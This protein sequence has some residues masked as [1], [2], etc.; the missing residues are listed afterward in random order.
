[1]ASFVAG[2]N[3]FALLANAF[4]GAAKGA[5]DF[6]QLKQRSDALKEQKRQHDDNLALGFN[7]LDEQIRQFDIGTSERSRLETMALEARHKLGIEQ[8]QISKSATLGAASIRSRTADKDRKATIAFQERNAGLDEHVNIL[9]AH[10]VAGLHTDRKAHDVRLQAGETTELFDWERRADASALAVATKMSLGSPPTQAQIS[11]ARE[12]V[13]NYPGLKEQANQNRIDVAMSKAVARAGGGRTGGG[14]TGTGAGVDF[15]QAYSGALYASTQG[16][17]KT[18]LKRVLHTPKQDAFSS[19]RSQM[20]LDGDDNPFTARNIEAVRDVERASLALLRE[21]SPGPRRTNLEGQLERAMSPKSF[22]GVDP[23]FA[24]S[25]AELVATQQEYG[26]N[27]SLD[28]P[29]EWRKFTS[30]EAYNSAQLEAESQTARAIRP[31]AV[32]EEDQEKHAQ[33]LEARRATIAAQQVARLSGGGDDADAVTGA[34]GE[35]QSDQFWTFNV[36]PSL[37]ASADAPGGSFS[38][39]KPPIPNIPT[40]P[41]QGT[42]EYDQM[43]ADMQQFGG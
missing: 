25:V 3:K 29:N 39:P 23:S 21:H 36:G 38:I 42:P 2:P 12:W 41:A 18:G 10:N 4:T 5:N 7:R 9:E 30:K 34:V 6:A 19:I 33:K 17:P 27:T 24:S 16:D 20:A 11:L 13:D 32:K 22:I 31:D 1:M 43:L 35:L 14:Y 8:S 40:T 15:S 37:G 28:N 26:S